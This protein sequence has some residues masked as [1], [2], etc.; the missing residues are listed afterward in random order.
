ML[1]IIN[2]LDDPCY[3]VRALLVSR[4]IQPVGG[5]KLIPCYVQLN[6]ELPVS[7]F[8]YFN[9]GICVVIGWLVCYAFAISR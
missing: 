5:F 9:L 8:N 7:G 6:P 4:F 3:E 1:W 2:E